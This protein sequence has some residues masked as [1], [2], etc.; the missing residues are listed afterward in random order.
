MELIEPEEYLE[1]TEY[2][3]YF[4][5]KLSEHEAQIEETLEPIIDKTEEIL[6]KRH[7]K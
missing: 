5:T 4:K 7:K 1:H 6:Y 3:F 2:W